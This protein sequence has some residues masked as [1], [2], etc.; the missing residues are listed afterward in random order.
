MLD[1][2]KFLKYLKYVL[3]GIMVGIGGILPGISGGVL[4][5]IFGIYE[6]LMET[7]AHPFRNIPKNLK[8]VIPFSI[9]VGIGFIGFANIIRLLLAKYSSYTFAT[10]LGLTMG[11]LPSTFK[12]A[13]KKGI[14]KKSK[15]YF[16]ISFIISLSAFIIFK[17][18]RIVMPLNYLSYFICGIAWGIS[19]IIPGLS[20][21][22]LIMFLGLY[23]PMTEGIAK[24]DL[25]VILPIFLGILI[26]VV[27]LSKIVDYLFKKFYTNFYHIILGIIVSSILLTIPTYY[28][29][30]LNLILQIIFLI[31]GFVLSYMFDFILNKE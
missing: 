6:I 16:V 21:S 31:I 29:S 13:Q 18:N 7:L 24:L 23:Q 1:R 28:P 11:M 10:F 8:I 20:S 4:C 12:E 25:N 3:A 15:L 27:L 2:K 30:F 17:I 26:I 22:I 19:I 9:G 14:S 5:V